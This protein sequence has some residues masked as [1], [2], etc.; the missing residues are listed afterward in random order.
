MSY[1]E[2]DFE[3]MARH[4]TLALTEA[5]PGADA[6]RARAC[7]V[8]AQAYHWADRFDLAQP[9]YAQAR[10][11][12]TQEGDETL[13]SALMLNM[14]WLRA[15]QA[16]RMAVSGT[17]DPAQVRQVLLGAE[18]SDHFDQRIGIGSL[19]SLAPMLRALVLTLLDRYAEALELFTA[20]L[21]A[22]LREGLG[23]RQCGP[24]AE[25]AWC[26]V[27]L[28]DAEGARS[29]A[30]QAQHRIAE[31]A[32]LDERAATH[33]RLSQI[34]TALNEP[35]SALPHRAQAQSDWACHGERQAR[36]LELL[37]TSAGL[38]TAPPTIQA[39]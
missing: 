11:H 6:A 17:A 30:L 2:M 18:S 10:Q 24:L 14:S 38:G 3:A 16:R 31:S 1:L 25:M 34:F 37:S 21:D 19:H 5:A 33:G 36:L 39:L 7:L 9:W 20:H 8:A 27:N 28:G 26:R 35:Q 22:A 23:Q 29:A 32:G 4:L 13:L 15:A 12:A